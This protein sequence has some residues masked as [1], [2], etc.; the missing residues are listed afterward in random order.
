MK[1]LVMGL[2]GLDLGVRLDIHRLSSGRDLCFRISSG[3]K[4]LFKASL[5]SPITG[6]RDTYLL[7]SLLARGYRVGLY[8]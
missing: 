8:I 5:S 7:L 1:A 6:R 2:D 4:S 3:D